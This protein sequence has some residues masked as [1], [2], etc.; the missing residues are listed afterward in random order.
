MTD[1]LEDDV[2]EAIRAR[3]ATGEYLDRMP[4]RPV[5]VDW[6][7]AAG[8]PA[9]L[10]LGI[11]GRYRSMHDRLDPGFRAA[12]DAGL[13]PALPPLRTA[14]AQTVSACEEVLG[15]PLP[16]LLRR[17]YLELGNGGRGPGYGL[18]PLSEDADDPQPQSLL[19]EFIRHRSGSVRGSRRPAH[20]YR[21]ATGVAGSSHSSTSATGPRRCGASTLIC[22]T[23]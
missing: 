8:R 4:G 23:S 13:I 1:H 11:D 14:T 21:S 9:V 6:S 3:V 18:L 22:L 16:P 12:R 5:E 10:Y 15:Q 19:D 17:C 20:S 2:L 7:T